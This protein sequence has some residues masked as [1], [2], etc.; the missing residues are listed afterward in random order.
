MF[1]LVEKTL[2]SYFRARSIF[3]EFKKSA[4][5][6]SDLEPLR[7]KVIELLLFFR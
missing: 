7:I 1:W 2:S 5:K 4:L 3:K 6:I